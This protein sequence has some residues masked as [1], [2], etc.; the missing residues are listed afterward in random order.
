MTK[1]KKL[2]KFT[3][4]AYS[5]RSHTKQMLSGNLDIKID[6]G[7]FI[8]LEDLAEDINQIN[9]TFNAYI[10]E[11]SH[12]LSHLSAGNMAVDFSKDIVYQGDFLPIKNALHK[13]RQSLNSSFKE[14]HRLSMEIDAMSNQVEGGSSFLAESTTQQAALLTDLTSTVF[15]ITDNT[16]QNAENAK[17]AA[18]AVEEI[19]KETEIGRGYMNNM[20]SSVDKVKSSIDDISQIIELI[21]EIAEQTRLLAF[22]ATIEAARAGEAG[23]GFSVV[24]G[25]IS[26]LAQKCSEAVGETAQLI[27]NSIDAV[28]EST[29]ITKKTVESFKRI[30]DSISKKMKNKVSEDRI[31]SHVHDKKDPGRYRK[32]WIGIKKARR[33][34]KLY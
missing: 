17:A 26:K 14:I 29:K 10:N 5:I 31:N 27:N 23:K 30:N 11:I 34:R 18:K 16:V 13:I 32:E 25:E 9:N 33:Y 28:D 6:T 21:N 3:E 15:D 20:L 1:K 4:E 19:T 8:F 24:A 22:N 12:I 7:H 2:Y